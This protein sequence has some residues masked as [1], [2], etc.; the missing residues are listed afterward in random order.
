MPA[1]VW[2]R[3]LVAE[4]GA[5]N[6]D[7]NQYVYLASVSRVLPETLAATDLCDMSGLSRQEVGEMFLD[8]FNNPDAPPRGGRPRSSK[9]ERVEKIVVFKELHE[10]GSP[11]FHVCVKL[12]KNMRFVIVKKTLRARHKLPSHWSCSHTHFCSAVRYGHIPSEKKP[13]VDA[14]PW[15]WTLNG[16]ELDLF[17][18]SQEP[19]NADVHRKRREKKDKDAIA[20]GSRSTFKKLDLNS[21]VISKHLHT[22][23]AL[24]AYVQVYGTE[25]MQA[26]MS[27]YQRN[28][29]QFIEDAQEWEEAKKVAITEAKTDW[30]LV[31]EASE[32]ACPHGGSCSYCKATTAIFDA[33]SRSVSQPKLAAALRDII[34]FGP[35][36]TCRVPFLIGPSNCGKKTPFF[37]HSMT[38]LGQR[39]SSTSLR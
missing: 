24:L 10:D 8:A 33:N 14:E 34:K 15:Q 21:L 2:F 35:K 5:E 36:K 26:F 37:I 17:A 3:A 16:E 9:V 19:F 31:V 1:E 4:L 39:V 13:I 30:D 38:F 23:A 7:A 20:K 12:R 22:R 28:L 11:H 25:A 18:E 32:Q 6:E 27:K 29:N